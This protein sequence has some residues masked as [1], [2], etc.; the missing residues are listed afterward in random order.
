MFVILEEPTVNISNAKSLRTSSE[1]DKF[2]N[3]GV[4]PGF[5]AFVANKL[6]EMLE[7]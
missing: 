7:R 5:Q 1:K 6:D 2:T 3:F 4:T